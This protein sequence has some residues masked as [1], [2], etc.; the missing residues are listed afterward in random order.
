MLTINDL[1]AKLMWESADD[2]L[3][4]LEIDTLDMLEALEDIVIDHQDKLREYYED[5]ETLD[6]K[7]VPDESN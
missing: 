5:T 3:D 4:L 7:E 2:I 6:G 1:I